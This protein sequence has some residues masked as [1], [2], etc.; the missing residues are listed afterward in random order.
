FRQITY[1]FRRSRFRFCLIMYLLA[2]IHRLQLIGGSW[3]TRGLYYRDPKMIL[4]QSYIMAA[5]LDVCRI[6]RTTP[7]HI[8]ILQGSKGLVSG[9]I[10]L[11]MSNGDVVDCNL[12]SRAITLPTDFENVER[13]MTNAEFV[14]IVEKESV[15]ENL[16]AH[17]AYS[18]VDLNFIIL[19]GKGYPDFTTRRMV[20]K[21]SFECNL[22]M[23]I[24]VDADP[25]GIEIMLIYQHGSQSMNLASTIFFNPTLMWIGLHPSEI[26]SISYTFTCLTNNDNKKIVDILSRGNLSHGVK[27]ELHTLQKLQLKAEIESLFDILCSSYLPMKIKR[28]LFL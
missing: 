4:S 21:L 14:L 8:G 10:A 19:T 13:I 11:H 28:K 16:L 25:F 12:Y 24:L 1:N 22:P 26:R 3:T 9:D 17:K 7:V 6:L 27:Y 23:Y 2:E 5:Q 15:F 20:H 18:K